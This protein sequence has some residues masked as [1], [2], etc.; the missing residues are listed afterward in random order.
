MRWARLGKTAWYLG[1][2]VL[3]LS[4][5]TFS[6]LL[7]EGVIPGGPYRERT[8][9][10][11]QA[12]PAEPAYASSFSG[13]GFVRSSSAASVLTSLAVGNR[14]DSARLLSPDPSRLERPDAQ[15]AA[16]SGGGVDDEGSGREDRA[17]LSG[18][19]NRSGRLLQSPYTQD[20]SQLEQGYDSAISQLFG[21]GRGMGRLGN[22]FRDAIPTDGNNG[23]SGNNGNNDNNGN[24]GGNG[25]GNDGGGNPDPKPPV[26]GGTKPPPAAR[27]YPFLVVHSFP[28][29]ASR[30]K[31]FLSYRDEDGR[32]VVENKGSIGPF[33]GN[34]WVSPGTV[35][36]DERQQVFS[37]DVDGDGLPDLFLSTRSTQGTELQLYLGQ[38]S[39]GYVPEASGFFLWKSIAGLALLDFDGDSTLDLVLLFRNTDNLHVYTIGDGQFKYLKEIVLPFVPSLM[40]D[41]LFDNFVRE[42]RL[43]VFDDSLRRVA[44]LTAR[45]PRVFLIGLQGLTQALSTFRVDG[46]GVGAAITEVLAFQNGGRISLATYQSGNWVVFGSFTDG[47]GFQTAVWGDY[48]KTG[49]RQLFCLP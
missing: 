31:V 34:V 4:L 25:G 43:H 36:T 42:R 3:I 41:S 24:N 39:G 17:D 33:Y 19:R 48:L 11:R 7:P 14:R 40:V 27:K 23:D 38:S 28:G 1:G 13:R 46:E 44:S 32:F 15:R 2:T 22:P 18:R 10:G 12:S 16:G 37:D 8:W 35:E 5:P 47:F 21:G 30:E 26:D 45:N 9:T 49:S 20:L 6:Y 29:T